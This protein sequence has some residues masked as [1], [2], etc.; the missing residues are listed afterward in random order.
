MGLLSVAKRA[1]RLLLLSGAFVTVAH[2]YQHCIADAASLFTG[3]EVCQSIAG[4][5]VNPSP[6][7]EPILIFFRCQ[8]ENIA[9][10]MA[11]AEILDS[12]SRSPPQ[13]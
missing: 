1:G 7:I 5:S 13:S 4:A 2:V 12:A 3:C 9:V 11:E 10:R 6:A 8:P